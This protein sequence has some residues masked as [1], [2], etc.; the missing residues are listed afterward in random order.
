MQ[1]LTSQRQYEAALK[2]KVEHEAAELYY[3][4]GDFHQYVLDTVDVGAASNGFYGAVF[5]AE[6]CEAVTLFG[7]LKN[8]AEA[9]VKYHYYDDVEPNTSQYSRDNTEATRFAELI[10]RA[11]LVANADGEW[12][13]WAAR[14]GWRYAKINYAE[15]VTGKVTSQG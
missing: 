10:D 2:A 6:R 3:I 11:N 4:D 15:Q 12:M 7:Y 14:E 1:H 5:A 8:W 9:G 13:A